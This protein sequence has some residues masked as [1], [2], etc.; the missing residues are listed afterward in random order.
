[1]DKQEKMEKTGE[2]YAR[3]HE[4]HEDFF[5]L[6]SKHTFLHWDWWV[7][8]GLSLLTWYLWWKVRRKE[9]TQRLLYVGFF[10]MNL[11]FFLDYLGTSAGL[12]YYSGKLTP[13]MPAYLPFNFAALPVLTMLLVQ[14]KPRLSRYIKA[15]LYGLFNAF[16]GEPLFVWGGFYV[17]TGWEYYY[18]LPIYF[19][20]Y[21]IVHK[22]AFAKTFARIETD[23]L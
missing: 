1:M 10:M 8:V 21:L 17:M 18:S 19:V 9:S 23:K 16:V 14:W 2:I 20:I 7:S 15:L 11:S 22:I 13:T 4:V 6:W 5:E 3:F 12:W